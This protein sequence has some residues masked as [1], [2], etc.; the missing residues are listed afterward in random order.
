MAVSTCLIEMN[1]YNMYKENCNGIYNIAIKHP[2]EG[3]FYDDWQFCINNRNRHFDLSKM[4]Y[5][6]SFVLIMLSLLSWKVDG[7]KSA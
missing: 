5:N 6:M 7:L 3:N 1:I 4:E 2:G